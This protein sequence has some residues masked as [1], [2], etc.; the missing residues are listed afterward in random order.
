MAPFKAAR[1][2]MSAYLRVL[3]LDGDPATQSAIKKQVLP[4]LDDLLILPLS[5]A[6]CEQPLRDSEISSR[7]IPLD[8]VHLM[9]F[10]QEFAPDIIL[11][12]VVHRELG[13]QEIRE[14]QSRRSM[15]YSGCYK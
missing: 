9:P 1:D 11:P 3:F 12:C 2:G 15:L 8:L 4:Y 10:L 13:S 6:L 5:V 14:V 7:Y